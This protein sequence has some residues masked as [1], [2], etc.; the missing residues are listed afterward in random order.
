[1]FLIYALSIVVAYLI[2]RAIWYPRHPQLPLGMPYLPFL[3][4][5]PYLLYYRNRW[6]D[7]TLETA[8]KHE[9]Y[10]NRLPKLGDVIYT[11][12]A[13]NV[14]HILSN[15]ELYQ[16]PPLRR[17][18]LSEVFGE[19][20]FM[21]NGESWKMQRNLAKDF[22]SLDNRTAM[23]GIYTSCAHRLMK[24]FDIAMEKGVSIDVQDLFKRFTLETFCLVAFGVSPNSIEKPIPFSEAFDWLQ[25]E[26]DWRFMD[27]TRSTWNAAAWKNNLAIFNDFVFDIIKKRRQS[28]LEDGTDYL[29]VLLRLERTEGTQE[30]ADRFVKDQIA[31]F[32]IAGR[33]TTA[34]LLAWTFYYLSFHPKVVKQLKEELKQELG[35]DEPDM[36]NTKNLKYMR[37]V[38]DEVLRL[39]PPAVPISS[40]IVTQDDTLPSGIHLKKGE[41]VVLMPPVLHRIEKYW[42]TDAHEFKPERWE[43]PL[44]HAWQFIPFQ[45]GPRQCI[46]MNMAYEEAKCVLSMILQ[47]N[48]ELT[49]CGKQSLSLL[50]T[51]ILQAKEGVS[52]KVSKSS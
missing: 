13:E 20:I 40:K 41:H 29:S 36:K 44:T 52:M 49:Y 18:L 47:H 32:I 28:P 27:P 31:N 24:Q 21:V 4:S 45:K 17:D 14:K 39:H 50:P 1:M 34:I 43:Q 3:G 38:L 37:M 35:D 5:V 22:F 7:L 42:G 10:F 46:G 2:W 26:I 15:V 23:F 6:I 48:Y 12:D 8:K 25:E 9:T 30:M 19:G 11:V 51:P 16:L 33:D